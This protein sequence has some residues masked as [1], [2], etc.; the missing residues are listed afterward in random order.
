MFLQYGESPIVFACTEG[1]ADVTSLLLDY[2]VG[3]DTL[4]PVIFSQLLCELSSL[5]WIQSSS[6]CLSSSQSQ[7]YQSF[8]REKCLHS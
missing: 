7:R 2:G 6:S 4:S 3:I 8:I 1:L 5:G